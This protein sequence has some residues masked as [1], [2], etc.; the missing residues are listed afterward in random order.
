METLLFLVAVVALEGIASWFKNKKK[1]DAMQVPKTERPSETPRRLFG[2]APNREVRH[3]ETR[4]IFENSSKE[5][6]REIHTDEPRFGNSHDVQKSL[7]EKESFD[8]N[9]PT[10][11]VEHLRELIRRFDADN[12]NE[13]FEPQPD[14]KSETDS[15]F[16]NDNDWDKQFEDY[17]DD[18][19]K[20]FE[21]PFDEPFDEP[22]NEPLEKPAPKNSSPQ[23]F[24]GKQQKST[25]FDDLALAPKSQS[26]L[27][28]A[29][30]PES[31]FSKKQADSVE[32]QIDTGN[33]QPSSAKLTNKPSAIRL[34]KRSAYTLAECAR[35][36][37]IWAKVIDEPRFKK[38]WNPQN[39]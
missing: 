39:R 33:H 10:D 26:S 20:D 34:K 15:D 27:E 1:R 25:L 37:F 8:K 31:V 4:G 21:K 28:H 7:S 12:P 24:E 13:D 22:F 19:F 30:F 2:D 9:L 18:P 11:P 35:N 38:R 29:S 14:F 5:G 17:D 23:E 3:R 6:R 32:L 16:P 36:G